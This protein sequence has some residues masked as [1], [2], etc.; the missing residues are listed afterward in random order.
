M[1]DTKP[2]APSQFDISTAAQRLTNVVDNVSKLPVFVIS[3]NDNAY[4]IR[5]YYTT[6]VMI[7]YI[8][9]RKIADRICRRYNK[10]KP[11][12]YIEKRTLQQLID[13]Y[14]VLESE[15]THYMRIIES[16]SEQAVRDIVRARYL[17]S[18]DKQNSVE[19]RILA[20]I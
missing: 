16:S 3:K 9:T 6:N 10:G 15:K 14:M 19:Q 17:T 2:S 4:E 7:N 8:P 18:K 11:F 12:T 20:L 13:S 5:N 1:L